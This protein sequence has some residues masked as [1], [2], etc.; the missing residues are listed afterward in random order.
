VLVVSRNIS[1]RFNVHLCN[2]TMKGTI[3]ADDERP[4]VSKV[5][6]LRLWTVSVPRRAGHYLA[7]TVKGSSACVQETKT[8][9]RRS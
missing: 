1:R 7:M 5:P 9:S 2:R 4:P 8:A 3:G 6:V